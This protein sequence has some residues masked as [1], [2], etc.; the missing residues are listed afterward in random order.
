LEEEQPRGALIATY[1]PTAIARFPRQRMMAEDKF[2]NSEVEKF[3]AKR[4]GQ[5]QRGGT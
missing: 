1:Q 4:L 3:F 2:Y 5:Y